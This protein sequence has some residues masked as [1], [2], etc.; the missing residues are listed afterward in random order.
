MDQTTKIAII[1]VGGAGINTIN[2]LTA[3]N[4]SHIKYWAIDTDEVALK[5]S[6][7]QEKLLF[8]PLSHQPALCEKQKELQS[9]LSNS[10]PIFV[11]AGMGGSFATGAVSEIAQIAKS[12]G[13]LTF[14]LVTTPFQFEGK[15][16]ADAANDSIAVLQ[17]NTDGVIAISNDSLKFLI[18]EHATFADVFTISDN[19]VAELIAATVKYLQ[20]P[21]AKICLQDIVDTLPYKEKIICTTFQKN[22]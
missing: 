4:Q 7:A 2:K 21:R 9:K 20:I 1:G 8:P 11:V 16:R 22:S 12:T 10:N 6:L 14:A 19:I 15:N 18:P 5:N 13:A 17:Q 3:S